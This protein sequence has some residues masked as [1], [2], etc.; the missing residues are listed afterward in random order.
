MRLLNLVLMS[1]HN[2]VT[3]WNEFDVT[4]IYF[5][6]IEK[7][8]LVKPAM[9]VQK[10]DILACHPLFKVLFCFTICAAFAHLETNLNLLRL[11]RSEPSPE[12]QIRLL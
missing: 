7:L 10:C 12:L 11:C 8:I 9:I 5:C 4:L 1:L 6:L 3:D 2:L